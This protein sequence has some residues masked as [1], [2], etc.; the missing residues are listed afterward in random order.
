LL[1][2]S[3]NAFRP[4]DKVPGPVIIALFLLAVFAAAFLAWRSK[5]I[6][7]L[8]ERK[9]VDLDI[10]VDLNWSA[11]ATLGGLP[12]QTVCG[13][14]VRIRNSGQ[15][16]ALERW[17]MRIT[18]PNSTRT[19]RLPLVH[20]DFELPINAAVLYP[21]HQSIIKR[22]ESP[23]QSGSITHGVAL[24]TIDPQL[25]VEGAVVT[26]ECFDVRG[27]P[28]RVTSTIKG[29]SQ[30]IKNTDPS[31]GASYVIIPEARP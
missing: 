2:I 6:E 28:H 23:L 27:E 21:S 10:A 16:T 8:E 12:E 15:P 11:T 30:S 19:V 24:A 9:R 5:Q 1:A 3:W 26:L 20:F 25:L 17:D 18:A 31:A 14:F 22:T 4:K 13:L 7:L 29:P